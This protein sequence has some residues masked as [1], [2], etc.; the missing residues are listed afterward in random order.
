MLRSTGY[1][2]G[3]DCPFLN[4]GGSGPGRGCRR[5]YCHFRHPPVA[6]A[7]CG[8]SRASGDPS[9][10]LPLGHGAGTARPGRCTPSPSPDPLPGLYPSPPPPARSF[11]RPR[12]VCFPPARA[13][14]CLA[15]SSPSCPTVQDPDLAPVALSCL[16]PSPARCPPGLCRY[17]RWSPLVPVPAGALPGPRVPCPSRGLSPRP[18]SKGGFEGALQ[19]R[20]VSAMRVAGIAGIPRGVGERIPGQPQLQERSAA[21]IPFFVAPGTR[22][23][24]C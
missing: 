10:G 3:I 13:G 24:W 16:N 2:R 9:A 8:A 6:P 18:C 14:P 5:P 4:A 7:P 23:T 19:P 15:L 22:L 20:R 1:F 21:L 12:P 11:F 17:H